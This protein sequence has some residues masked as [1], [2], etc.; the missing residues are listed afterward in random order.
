MTARH[1]IRVGGRRLG[2]ERAT[3]IDATAA[4]LLGEVLRVARERKGVDLYRAERDTKIRVKHLEALEVGAWSELPGA[5][6]TKGFLR[7][8]ALYLGLD[9]DEIIGKWRLETSV[10]RRTETVAVKPPRPLSEPRRGLTFS[11]GIL[12]AAM[13]SLA[14]V[15]F[16]G[17]VAFQVVRFNEVP[18]LSL[19]GPPVVQLGLNAESHRLS[20]DTVAGFTVTVTG[21]GD[22]LRTT[23]ADPAGGWSLEVPVV[24]GR[25]DFTVT[26]AAADQLRSSPPLT[27]IITV[28]VPPTAAPASGPASPSSA[29]VQLVLTGP[30]EAANS[31]DGR[32][33]VAG[34]SD[35][36]SVTVVARPASG[37]P[38]A[39]AEPGRSVAPAAPPMA[40]TLAADGSFS[41]TLSLAEGSWR[42]V[43]NASR[44][45]AASTEQ[46]RTVTV[47]LAGVNV[48]IEAIGGP[49]YLEIS[50]DGERSEDWGAGHILRRGESV[51]IS[52]ERTVF[53]RAGNSGATFFT[54]NGR[55]LGALGGPGEVENWIF[56]KGQPPR[57]SL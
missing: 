34:T 52:G 15:A 19:D 40:V 44:P 7:N 12:V 56:E 27:V 14:I 4:P 21:A 41:Q 53:V 47:E 20:G 48:L 51:T 54:V 11:R 37:E 9:P 8:Y 39:S 3:P 35:G 13:V 45:G 33:V 50:V 29:P 57:R 23:E 32:I 31:T 17:Y 30:A 43:V 2:R 28:P 26:A 46:A 25:N 22:L 1:H 6:Y 49:T 18:A 10:T 38:V 55:S 5:V 24:R 16:A 42:I 36:S